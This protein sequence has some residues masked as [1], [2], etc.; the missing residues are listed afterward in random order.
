[1]LVITSV[2]IPLLATASFFSAHDSNI[3]NISTGKNKNTFLNRS[4]L[5]QSVWCYGMRFSMAFIAVFLSHLFS[6]LHLKAQCQPDTQCFD[7]IQ[8]KLSFVTDANMTFLTL[9]LVCISFS[10][11]SRTDHLWK[12]RLKRSWHIGLVAL[13]IVVLQSLYFL[14]KCLEVNVEECLPLWSWIMLGGCIPV[15]VLVNELIRRHEIKVNV[16][17]Q[18]RARLDFN[19]KLG[20]NSP[21]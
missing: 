17:F 20:I 13:L 1:M 11:V 10:F 6:L 3:S 15:Q 4:T 18:R 7:T 12:Y 8:E 19:T 16:R 14:L 5:W 21:F 9:Y 2:Y